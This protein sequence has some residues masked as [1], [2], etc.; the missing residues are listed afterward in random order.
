M[1][2][3]F[4][5]TDSFAIPSLKALAKEHEIQAV[6]TRPDK[7]RG[8]G[9]K[10]SPTPVKK[11]ANELGLPVLTP[12][13]LKSK[14]FRQTLSELDYEAVVVVA[15]GRILPEDFIEKPA[16][17]CICLHPSILPCYRGCS[18]I[19][20]AILEGEKKTGVS[21]FYVEKDVD[22]GDIIYQ[23]EFD[24]GETE[25]GGELRKKLS[26]ESAKVLLKALGDVEN[27]KVKPVPQDLS[28]ASWAPKI[29]KEDARIDWKQP[30]KKI[31]NKIRAF[32]PKPG[33]FT[34]FRGKLLK[35][36]RARV[37]PEETKQPPGT[38]VELVKGEGFSVACGE[39]AL[40]LLKVQPPG[41]SR[42]SAWSFA[43]GHR[44]QPG[45]KLGEKVT[46]K[47]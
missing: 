40:V 8:R 18:P 14:S 39:G 41:K 3:L 30:A 47:T 17:G 34:Y 46:Q 5:G 16:K 15:Y 26:R 7:P 37:L 31:N 11:A 33:A 35:I 32:N 28:K 1:K 45:E 20:S 38:I 21:V 13:N 24:I 27:E 4:M 44:P 43:M 22:A 23:Q 9:R 25:T 2:I 36:F 42:M 12:K 10:L 6:V 29:K 19:E